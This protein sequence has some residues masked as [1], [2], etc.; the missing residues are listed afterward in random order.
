MH[1]TNP[2]VILEPN[3]ETVWKHGRQAKLTLTAKWSQMCRY[4]C[5]FDR[6]EATR[7]SKAVCW[8]CMGYDRKS[9]QRSHKIPEWSGP[10]NGLH[11]RSTCYMEIKKLHKKCV[12]KSEDSVWRERIPFPCTVARL[13]W[14]IPKSCLHMCHNSS[15]DWSLISWVVFGSKSTHSLKLTWSK[16]NTADT[17]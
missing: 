15:V 14:I 3:N 5:Y 1:S 12:G 4:L 10:S 6:N 9:N 17:V 8:L 2:A 7:S 16:T 11:D 13:D